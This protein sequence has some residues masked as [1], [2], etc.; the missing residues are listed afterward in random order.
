M[1]SQ[2]EIVSILGANGCGKSTLLRAVLGLQTMNSGNVEIDGIPLSGY[3]AAML[4]RKVAFYLN[5]QISTAT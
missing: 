4:A 3:S 5:Q 2:G 1:I